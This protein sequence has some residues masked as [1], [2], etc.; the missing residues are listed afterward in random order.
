MKNV[1]TDAPVNVDV[2]TAVNLTNLV[3]RLEKLVSD[4]DETLSVRK[5]INYKKTK[6]SEYIARSPRLRSRFH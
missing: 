1:N 4:L 3:V 5:P 2:E 6:T